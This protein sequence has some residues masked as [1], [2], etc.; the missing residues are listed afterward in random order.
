MADPLSIAAGIIAI[1]TATIQSSTALYDTIESFKNYPQR[2]KDLLKQ[3]SSLTQTLDSLRELSEQDES[4]GVS[5]KVPLREC[6]ATCD[7]F[8]RLLS[9]HRRKLSNGKVF[10]AWMHLKFRN[11]DVVNFMETLTVYKSTIAIAIAD[12]NL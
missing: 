6:G 11:G 3:L 8:G 4:V 7:G 5:L 1:I 10:S 12:A 2:V 9:V